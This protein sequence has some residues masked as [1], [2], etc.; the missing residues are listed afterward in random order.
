MPFF[1][2]CGQDACM[3]LQTSDDMMFVDS[4]KYIEV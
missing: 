4:G 2:W 3:A 1:G